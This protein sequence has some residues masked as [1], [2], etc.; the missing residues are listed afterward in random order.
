MARDGNADVKLGTH[1]GP[2][3]PPWAIDDPRVVRCAEAY[4]AAWQEG[5]QPNRQE[6]LCRF[7]ELAGELAQC[8][9]AIDFVERAQARAN[10][11][12]DPLKEPPPGL[13]SATDANAALFLAQVHHRLDHL[14]LARRWFDK[15]AEWMDKNQS[16]DEKL[17]RYRTEAA[18]LLQVTDTRPTAGPNRSSSPRT[19][20]NWPITNLELQ[21]SDPTD[22]GPLTTDY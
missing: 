15:A 11:S 6:L 2:T 20:D 8:L 12:K 18:K 3:G 13:R 17:R 10:D 16:D 19:T 14:D 9:D 1:P 4:L 21:I 22:Q 5:K 7:P